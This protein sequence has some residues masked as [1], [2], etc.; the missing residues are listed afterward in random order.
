LT[1][2]AQNALGKTRL[3]TGQP[4]TEVQQL[5]LQRNLNA[6]VENLVEAITNPTLRSNIPNQFFTSANR[7]EEILK[8]I[9]GGVSL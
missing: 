9:A 8:I 5:G 3:T 6:A 7:I 2:A 4:L 1:R